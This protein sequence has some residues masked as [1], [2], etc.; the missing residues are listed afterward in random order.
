[1]PSF[2]GLTVLGL[3]PF[4]LSMACASTTSYVF[5]L[6]KSPRRDEGL[7]DDGWLGG[8]LN[9][10]THRTSVILCSPY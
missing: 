3:W 1:M 5:V 10:P 6:R 4:L 9:G 7:P 2:H 8:F